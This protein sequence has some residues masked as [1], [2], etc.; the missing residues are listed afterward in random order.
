[1]GGGT[2]HHSLGTNRSKGLATLFSPKIKE[3]NISLLL[4]TDRILMSSVKID[5]TTLIIIN[6]YCPCID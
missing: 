4:K 1:M 5:C 2:V 3:E 6:V